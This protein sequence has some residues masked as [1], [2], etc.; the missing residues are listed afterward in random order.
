MRWMLGRN[1][2]FHATLVDDHNVRGKRR[3]EYDVAEREDDKNEEHYEAMHVEADMRNGNFLR[4]DGDGKEQRTV[5][6]SLCR[7]RPFEH[8][9]G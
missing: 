7:L 8:L 1:T 2:H 3:C 4:G 6:R 5:G 9:F